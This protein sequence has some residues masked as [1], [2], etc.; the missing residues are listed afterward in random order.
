MKFWWL[1]LGVILIGCTE[2]FDPA[3][4]NKNFCE[5]GRLSYQAGC[6]RMLNAAERTAN[7]ECEAESILF[8]K[9][10]LSGFCL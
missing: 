10:N 1:L 7:P 6:M 8:G 3:R 4:L 9:T 5:I 2:Q